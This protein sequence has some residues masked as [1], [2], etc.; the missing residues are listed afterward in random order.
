MTDLL[1]RELSAAQEM[2]VV[3]TRVALTSFIMARVAWHLA[4]GCDTAEKAREL[5]LQEWRVG[6]LGEKAG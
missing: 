4:N 6:V 1:N 3:A 2:E 5:A